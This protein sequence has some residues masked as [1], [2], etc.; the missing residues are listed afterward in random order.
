MRSLKT[1]AFHFLSI[2]ALGT[3]ASGCLTMAIIAALNPSAEYVLSGADVSI[4]EDLSYDLHLDGS[5]DFE[6]RF[7]FVAQFKNISNKAITLSPPVVHIQ[8]HK[9]SF[10]IRSE[11]KTDIII[12][13]GHSCLIKTQFRVL[14][15]QMSNKTVVRIKYRMDEDVKNLD[16]TLKKVV[17]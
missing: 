12:S 1:T 7:E 2:I 13:P 9:R 14:N 17:D 3:F 16:I 8:N 15:K 4:N 6:D 5:Q 11:R 10:R